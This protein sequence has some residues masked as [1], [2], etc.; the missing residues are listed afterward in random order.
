[1][2]KLDDKKSYQFLFSSTPREGLQ[3]A[4][5]HLSTPYKETDRK[6]HTWHVYKLLNCPKMRSQTERLTVT[7]LQ[8]WPHALP[9]SSAF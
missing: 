2:V 3:S 6:P 9:L 8:S 4:I 7:H 5:A 1:M